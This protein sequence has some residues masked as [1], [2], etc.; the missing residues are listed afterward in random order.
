[1]KKIFI[2]LGVAA[3]A[4]QGAFAL[5]SVPASFPLEKVNGDNATQKSQLALLVARYQNDV[6]LLVNSSEAFAKDVQ[7]ITAAPATTDRLNALGTAGGAKLTTDSLAAAVTALVRQNPAEAPNVVASA[8]ELLRNLPGGLSPENREKIARAAVQGLPDNL[9][10]EPRIVAFVIGVAARGLNAT[11]VANL[12]KSVRGFVIANAPENAQPTLALAVDE[13]LVDAG[14]LTPH[15]AT[16]EFLAM[17]DNFASD[18]LAETFFSG[19]Q[20]VINQGAFF[21]PGSA[22]SAGGAGSTGNQVQPTP[23]PAPPAS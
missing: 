21:A 15:S 4:V 22:G 6:V 16:P 7:D 17:A 3:L 5:I 1:M 19:D 13:A 12:V 11:E 9:R 2:F 23:T 10:D 18:Q 8:L 20:G 14:V